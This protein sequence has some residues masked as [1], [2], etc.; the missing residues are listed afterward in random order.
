MIHL[1]TSSVFYKRRM[2][3]LL[4]IEERRFH[5]VIHNPKSMNKRFKRHRPEAGAQMFNKDEIIFEVL[6]RVI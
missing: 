1:S 4:N 2:L 5:F 3:V 6:R